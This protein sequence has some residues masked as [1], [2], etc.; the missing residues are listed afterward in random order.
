MRRRESIFFL[1][2]VTPL[3][4]ALAFVWLARTE[5]RP[6]PLVR[7]TPTPPAALPPAQT[8]VAQ[9]T[10]TLA[11]KIAVTPVFEPEPSKTREAPAL[12]SSPL[13]VVLVACSSLEVGSSGIAN[14]RRPGS[15][16]AGFG[17]IDSRALRV[18]F[19]RAQLGSVFVGGRGLP[20]LGRRL[21]RLDGA[22]QGG[23]D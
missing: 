1:L 10:P 9:T 16:E 5:Q 22:R 14:R 6:R 20:F 3:V 12:I 7:V 18:G 4:V 21:R 11:P 17:P 15:V 19:A 13:F 8:T 2:M 23:G